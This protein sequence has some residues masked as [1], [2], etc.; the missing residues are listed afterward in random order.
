MIPNF[1]DTEQI[2]PGDRMTRYR[3]GAG[4]RRRAGR[5]VR[6]QRRVL[7]VARPGRRRSRAAPRRD[8]PDQRR[9]LDA[10]RPGGA[11]EPVWRTSGSA[12][13]CPANA[14]ASCWPPA[15]STSCRCAAASPT[16]ACRRRPTRSSPPGGRCSPRSTPGRRSRA[17]R[18]VGGRR[19]RRA[20]RCRAVHR[21]RRRP[22]RRPP[23]LGDDGRGR[24][25]V[26]RVGSVGGSPPPH[27]RRAE[28]YAALI[29]ARWPLRPLAPR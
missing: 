23:P 26:G 15:T 24:T 25:A 20:G 3:A 11:V 22:R 8:V 9:R 4:D 29:E 13:S 6:R 5:V 1:V 10:Q 7:A 21:R 17:P 14:S 19:Q 2:Q 16:S 27:G 18:R 28:A 12:A